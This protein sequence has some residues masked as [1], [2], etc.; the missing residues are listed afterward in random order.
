MQA[1]SEGD[2]DV[3]QG[4]QGS[5][6]LVGKT[7]FTFG[8]QKKG[9]DF[10]VPSDRIKVHSQLVVHDGGRVT[11]GFCNAQVIPCQSSCHSL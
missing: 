8:A 3:W 9:G 11:I 5:K 1:I 10:Y 7:V 6:D 4:N 2:W